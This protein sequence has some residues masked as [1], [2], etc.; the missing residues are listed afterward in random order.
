MIF[1]N[2]QCFFLP[3]LFIALFFTAIPVLAQDSTKLNLINY[4]TPQE[5]EIGGIDV[6]GTQ[7]LDKKILVNLSGLSV[8]DKLSV[9]GEELP[10]AM[11]NLWKQGLF[12]DIDIYAAKIVGD[13]IFL[14]IALKE[15]V[16]LSKYNF[17]GIKKGEEE[18]LRDQIGL[19]R[20]KIV[21]ENLLNNT[22]NAILKFYRKKGFLKTTVNITQEP[23]AMF[24]NSVKLTIDVRKNG[25]VKIND[26]VFEGVE[27]VPHRK[28]K[29]AM[30]ET[31]ERT[32]LVKDAPK[33]I[34]R[35]LKKTRRPAEA[36]GNIAPSELLNYV[37]QNIFRFKLFSSS[38][39]I[40]NEFESDKA[41][42]IAQYNELGYRD[43]R[44]LSDTVYFVDD[45]NI[46]V[47]IKVHEGN[48]YYFR[49]IEWRG[50]NKYDDATLS[51]ILGIKRGE[52]YNQSLLQSRLFIDPNGSDV[53]SLYMDDGYLFFNVTPVEK[54]VEGDSIDLSI[55]VYEG[56][57]ATINRVI[58]TGNDKTNE[59]VI[60]RELRTLPGSKFS[61]S[62]IIRSQ[63][64]IANL[65]FFDPEQLQVNPIPNPQNGTVDI[66]YK[67]VEKPSDQ[68]E[69]SAGWGGGSIVG[70]IGV[71]FN[72]FSLRNIPNPKAWRPL[73]AG[74]GQRLT[75]RFQ[76]TGKAYQS[77]NASF[78]EPWLGGKRPNAFTVSGFSS[79]SFSNSTIVE[80]SENDNAQ[81][82]YI[83]GLS[84]GLGRRL[85][86][87]DDNFT[88]QNSINFQ[89]Y[90]L[91]NWRTD[92][93][94]SNG[95]ANNLSIGTTIARYS[96]DAPI[97][98]RRGSNISLEVQFT[99]PYSLFKNKDYKSLKEN[100]EFEELYKWTEY[101]KW[102]FKAEWYTPIVGNLVLKTSAKLGMMGYY[103]K[104]IGHTPFERFELGGDGI[105]NF[106]LYGKDIIA[107][108][109]YDEGS[110]TRNFQEIEQNGNSYT[111]NVGDPYYAKY[112]LE[113]R[114]PFSLN[115]SSTI[116][117]LAFVEAGNSWSSFKTFNP[118]QVK[119]SAGIGLRIF[120]PMF[121]TLGFDY[122][123]GFDNVLSTPTTGAWDYI[124]R[125]GRFSIILGVEP[126]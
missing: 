56:P 17:K 30:K 90:N 124:G 9:P 48:R 20:G 46:K 106:N 39:F 109:G 80:D 37:D 61:R 42:V 51:K 44:I 110:I 94:I 27:Q 63:R 5:Y 101:H 55:Q 88:M 64:E 73:P 78:T 31:K 12:A 103:N 120:L 52:V 111:V 23:D 2:K 122:G 99:P 92:F 69:L 24:T 40:E 50:N 76:S 126:E 45:K 117:A 65:G 18:E 82:L 100:G 41:A 72:N 85:K 108:R 29:K 34:W 81:L 107:L 115:P 95:N 60:R 121:G 6:T 22:Q 116:Y 8:G 57:Q 16:R 3:C 36:L 14:E 59:H 25:K 83:S 4:A 89:R 49:N 43:A 91:K 47:E 62:D 86:W 26:I 32:H 84:V 19:I 125:K 21:N 1:L 28:L 87:P 66:E 123:V 79:R 97:Y 70:S 98:P 74:D 104:D 15:R 58:I 113:L 68:L 119:R 114:Y 112:T 75:F 33:R 7:H 96:V 35:D 38:K 54:A 10:K 71:S 102:K 53:S 11:R 67:V 118:F 105:S 77:I 13:V 93:I